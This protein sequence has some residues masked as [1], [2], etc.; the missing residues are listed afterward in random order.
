MIKGL[1][2]ASILFLSAENAA[3][4]QQSTDNK[5]EIPN[6]TVNFNDHDIHEI[7]SVQ[8]DEKHSF[9]LGADI[10]ANQ[11]IFAEDKNEGIVM[12]KYKFSF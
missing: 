12:A 2:A 7:I 8:F 4:W 9:K 5:V 6:Q 1:I 3:A 11:D 10:K